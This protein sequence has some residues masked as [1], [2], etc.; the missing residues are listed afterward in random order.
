MDLQEAILQGKVLTLLGLIR[1]SVLLQ[2][3]TFLLEPSPVSVKDTEPGVWTVWEHSQSPS[4]CPPALAT[5]VGTLPLPRGE[6][7]AWS[8]PTGLGSPHP[9]G[10]PKGCCQDLVWN[11]SGRSAL[12]FTSSSQ[13]GCRAA[14]LGLQ[15]HC[16]PPA[17]R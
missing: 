2:S 10:I 9:P 15:A 17:A 1:L 4:I 11:C 3:L 13:K 6:L 14:A 12:K 16:L 7:P 8:A 5:L